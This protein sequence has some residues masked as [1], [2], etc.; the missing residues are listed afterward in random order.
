MV[1]IHGHLD[2]E[3]DTIEGRVS[4]PGCGDFLLRRAD[5]P[6]TKDSWLLGK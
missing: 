1:N 6:P 3:K 5:G 4:G 2:R